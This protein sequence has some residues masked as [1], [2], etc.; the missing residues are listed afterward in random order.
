[1]AERSDNR[2]EDTKGRRSSAGIPAAKV[3]PPPLLGV[4]RDRLIRS[5]VDGPPG[6]RIVEGLAGCGKTT[7]LGHA[8]HG[9]SGH[10]V[11]VTVDGSDRVG[12]RFARALG[13]AA[14]QLPSR[15]GPGSGGS[16]GATDP[17]D[18]AE[19][20]FSLIERLEAHSEPA[21]VVIDDAHE[22]AGAPAARTV[23][24]LCRYRPAQV[25]LVLGARHLRGLEHWRWQSEQVRELN[26][27]S[28]RFRL[29]EVQALFR[30]HYGTPLGAEELHAVTRLTDG[31]AVALHLYQV[32][33]RTLSPAER[34]RLVTG[35]RLTVRSLREYLA[36]QVL[37]TVDADQRALLRRIAVLDRIRPDRCE[38]LLE[39]RGCTDQ[40]Q[41]L[42][43]LGLLLPE[44]D[45][46]T[47]RLHELLRA[48]LLGELD[49][50]LG[51][52]GV[53]GL[54]RLAADVLEAEGD[55]VE[56]VRACGRGGDWDG[57]RR[58][59]AADDDSPVVLRGPWAED[60]PSRLRDT[61]P[62]VLR[63]IGRRQLGEGDLGG[64]RSTLATSVERF[65]E[66]GG[67]PR[68]QRSL[69]LL[70]HWLDPDPGQQRSWTECLR[71]GL[72][73]SPVEAWPDEPAGWLAEGLTGLAAG[74]VRA[75]SARLRRAA[76]TLSDE[77]G[78][79]AELGLC[80]AVALS[81][82]DPMP[83][84]DR[85]LARARANGA[86]ALVAAA[87]S[88]AAFAAG[89]IVDPDVQVATARER[90]DV[91]GDGV[92]SFVTGLTFL[93]QELPA[94]TR[95]LDRATELFR[96]AGLSL[97]GSAAHAAALLAR[98]Q[99]EPV[100]VGDLDA[101]VAAARVIGP[102][103]H[104]LALLA[105]G[106]STGDAEDAEQAHALGRQNG[107]GSFLARL[108]GAA[109]KELEA[110]HR[111]PYPPRDLADTAELPIV[112][113]EVPEEPLEVRCMGDLH[114]ALGGVDCD[115]AQLRP[116]HQELLSILV[117]HPNVW[118]HREKL[119]EW[120]WPGTTTAKATRNLQVAI[121][122]VRKLVE[123]GSADGG[124]RGERK[125]IVRNGER[126]RMVV[127]REHSDVCRLEWELGSA[128][129]ALRSSDVV[130]AA[131]SLERA[132]AEWQGEPVPWVGPTDWAVE[133]RRQLSQQVGKVAIGVI[134]GLAERDRWDLAA[135][136]A[137]QAVE[138][139]DMDDRLWRLAVTAAAEAGSAV[140]A[141]N[142]EQRYRTLVGS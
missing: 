91:I 2:S 31:W 54:H 97:P 122:A 23:D 102:F 35:P 89:G 16:G 10:C 28:L 80:L 66:H 20:A 22:L 129:T 1:M 62:W 99:D 130:A 88:L 95:C 141:A 133:R 94:A 67:D 51:P 21:L 57:V 98:V 84:A 139:D 77:L 117:A 136:L 76:A 53:A 17:V 121:S 65:R 125:V 58:L 101:E 45:G 9:R 39:R 49:E 138:V 18:P 68:A 85:A 37:A 42:A 47:Y 116:R 106:C 14:S 93:C 108:P 74:R 109:T 82:P 55:I 113:T 124:Q 64:A 15:S 56:A 50:E 69:R 135:G 71:A 123:P 110:S 60:L 90:R 103:P 119:F 111:V 127:A 137:A 44:A 8:A 38:R 13:A 5:L 11:W 19:A 52:G 104:A 86:P 107:F 140:L 72:S 4:R 81:E 126:Y 134:G 142:L 105:R 118:L 83:A 6:V 120:L 61:D 115:V 73:G 24:L 34:R 70:E 114:V 48:H 63:A 46:V 132:L 32:A 131:T 12:S 25:T 59:L 43:R 40:L 96:D 100:S 27:D 75:A 3:H 112:E 128:Q 29:W 87:E 33:T 7:V 79:A 41:L 30:D 26:A 36:D 78:V 92:H